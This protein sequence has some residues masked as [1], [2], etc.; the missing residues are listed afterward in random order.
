MEKRFQE[1]YR[2]EPKLYIEGS[3]VVLEAGAL[4]KDNKINKVLVQLKIRNL[5][6]KRITACK[7]CVRAFEPNGTEIT[8]LPEYVYLDLNAVQGEDFGSR[9][10]VYLPD[11][12]TRKVLV[13]VTEIVFDDNNI[14]DNPP[15]QWKQIP[16]QMT[17]VERLTDEELSKQYQQEVG[18]DCDY[19]PERQKGLFLCTC[20]TANLADSAKCYK[21]HR[22]YED[23]I[24]KLDIDYLTAQKDVRIQKETEEKEAAEKAAAEAARKDR[25]EKEEKQLKVKK[26]FKI[27]IPVI[28]IALIIAVLTP[29]VIIP[30]IK[31]ATAYRDANALLEQGEYDAAETAF[32][33]LGD[34]R[35]AP[36]MAREAQYQKAESLV[37]VQK[38]EEAIELWKRLG[39]YSD[40]DK[41]IEEAEDEW[42]GDDYNEAVALM[43]EKAYA[44]ASKAFDSLGDYKDSKERSAKCLELKQ[45]EDYQKAV[46]DASKGEYKKAISG[47]KSLGDYKDAKD[48]YVTT[49]YT[50]ACQAMESSYYKTAIEYFGYAKGYKDADEKR[51]EAIYNY[52]CQSLDEK[53]YSLAIAEY[54][55]CSGYKDADSKIRDAKYGYVM[56]LWDSFDPNTYT[57]LKEL[58]S[59]NYPGAQ[60]AFNDLYKWKIEI[61]AI[62]NSKDSL[63]TLS[64][65]SVFDTVYYHYEV[66]GGEPG[67][68]ETL[69]AY[70]MLPGGSTPL[71]SEVVAN[72]YVGYFFAYYTYGYQPGT[73]S[74]KIYDSEGKEKASASIR[75]N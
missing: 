21:C 28:A 57:Y 59:A 16:A 43:E 48:L 15:C 9:I 4:L 32:K 34:Y 61:T 31:N 13:S 27:I 8:G 20:G 18:P 52:A 56:N 66:S 55:N 7:I 38:Y 22:S 2:L 23:L 17:I 60:D 75:M 44:K 3:P 71:R 40:C 46:S 64:S 58:I 24:E 68:K 49:S 35:D 47:F 26:I 33:N 6:E 54:K 74:I 69:T 36:D 5:A 12:T 37:A 39:D 50:Y 1:L 65:V 53:K 70:M 73:C 10:P 30:A 45:E 42:K 29:T 62:N 25:I 19:V 14:W 63:D 11:N 72:G 51:T 41:R 67:A